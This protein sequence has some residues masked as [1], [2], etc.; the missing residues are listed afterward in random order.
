VT[1]PRLRPLVVVGAV[2][3]AAVG[4]L[5]MVAGESRGIAAGYAVLLC[6][7]PACLTVWFAGWL[8]G[9]TKFAGILAMAVGTIVRAMVAV[10]GGAVVFLNVDAV[11]DLRFE[12]WA[13]ILGAYLITLA[14]ETA[15]LAKYFQ[16]TTSG[17]KGN[18]V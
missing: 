12:F 1:R 7:P 8:A 15:I 11:R 17:G 13:W 4:L 6:I 9:R 3:L 18:A 16:S 2:L 5:G 10:G 14:T